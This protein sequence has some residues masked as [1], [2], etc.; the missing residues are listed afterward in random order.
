[1]EIYNQTL[2][3]EIPYPVEKLVT[4]T[5]ASSFEDFLFFDIETTGLSADISSLYLIGCLYYREGSFHMIQWFADSYD[6]E[7]DLL[8]AFFAKL[9]EFKVLLHY[10]GQGFD[11]PYLQKKVLQYQL[12]HSFDGIESIDLYR[13]IRPFKKVLQ[14]PNLKQKTIEEFLYLSR[15]DEYTGKELIPIYGEY[16]KKK[17]SHEE[18]AQEQKLLL[19]HNDEDLKGMISLLALCDYIDLFNERHEVVQIQ[20]EETVISATLRLSRP[21]ARMVK[22][23][24]E[25]L[26]LEAHEDLLQI[27]VLYYEG[28]LKYFYKNYKDYYYL[29]AEDMAIHKS[30]AEYVDR[31]FKEK[32]KK[33][34]CYI[35]KAGVFL[36]MCEDSS[37]SSILLFKREVK[38]KQGFMEVS[39]ETFTNPE[40]LEDYFHQ[41]LCTLA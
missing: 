24:N 35:R 9:K 6:S 40:L 23:H 22:Y 21:I 37:D 33:A 25:G 36:P 3:L 1:M 27:H 20:K 39:A 17:F 31:D 4:R 14:L 18:N 11:I 15:E 5:N 2:Q 12:P 29:P 8:E 32:A 16:M 13:E 34:N 10:N 26:S 41:L 7:T 30:V 19:L 38:D 28:E